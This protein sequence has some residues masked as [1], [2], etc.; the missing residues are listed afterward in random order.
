MAQCY[1]DRGYT[2]VSRPSVWGHEHKKPAI[3]L[4]R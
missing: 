1:A 2:T 4:K 3:S